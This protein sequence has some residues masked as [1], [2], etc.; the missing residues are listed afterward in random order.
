MSDRNSMRSLADCVGTKRS[1]W[2]SQARL[3]RAFTAKIPGAGSLLRLAIDFGAPSARAAFRW[4]SVPGR[5]YRVKFAPRPLAPGPWRILTN[6]LP[7]TGIEREL[8]DSSTA[9][10]NGFYRVGAI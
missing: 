1:E 9:D 4:P 3:R 10:S 7:G 8:W 6:G 2:E 5:N